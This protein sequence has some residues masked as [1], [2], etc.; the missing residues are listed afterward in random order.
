MNFS[1]LF[2]IFSEKLKK[3]RDFKELIRGSAIYFVVKLLG[4]FVSYL[5]TLFVTRHYGASVWGLFALSLTVLQITSVIGRFG[6]DIALLRFIAE[7][8]SQG[9]YGLAKLVYKKAASFVFLLSLLL[10][11]GL[12]IS[13]PIISEDIFG[14]KN[15]T[16]FI[17]IAALILPAFT[18]LYLNAESL[19]ALKRIGLYII[20]QNVLPFSIAFAFLLLLT[21]LLNKNIYGVP[22]SYLV[23]IYVSCFLSFIFLYR[24][25]KQFNNASKEEIS[26]INLLSI[27]FPM[28]MAN[29][30]T[31][32]MSWTDV[33]MLG[34]FR[35]EFEVGIYS[36]VSKLSVLTSFTLA[37][38]NSIAAPKF[39]E[40]FSKGDLKSLEKFIQQTTKLIFLATIPIAFLFLMFSTFILGL[41][42]EDFKI[43]ALALKIL[44][45]GQ[46]INAAAGSV[47]YLLLMTGHQKFHQ[48]IIVI[49]FIINTLLNY[50]L[51][52]KLGIIGASVSTSITIIVG[53]V[54][55]VIYIKRNLGIK[56]Y[57]I[58]WRD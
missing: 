48:K 29:S 1:F 30:L 56:T 18:L 36:V 44:I 58:P 15:L 9:K 20:N 21:G 25:F 22:I 52:P 46:I 23:A 34:I 50:L 28:L 43:G 31:L 45:I 19:R 5:F 35:S 57:F 10:A 27:S 47:G 8:K 3:D 2:K 14:K 42:G 40:F 39:A 49:T 6:L 51:I 11:L 7:Y 24:E 55:S 54:I 26:L 32:I 16:V 13:A 53:N 38:I 17:E 33:I 41:F 37:A 4:I 12:Y